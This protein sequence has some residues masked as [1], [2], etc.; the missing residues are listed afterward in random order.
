[1]PGSLSEP[2]I[3]F[4]PGALPRVDNA[5]PL[6]DPYAEV[7]TQ[8]IP[9]LRIEQLYQSP[10]YDLTSSEW[11]AARAAFLQSG[12][13]LVG[14]EAADNEEVHIALRSLKVVTLHNAYAEFAGV[15]L[16]DDWRAP[17]VPLETRRRSKMAELIPRQGVV[18]PDPDKQLDHMDQ[19]YDALDEVGLPQLKPGMRT[20]RDV[21]ER[22]YTRLR[23]FEF[24]AKIG[25]TVPRFASLLYDAIHNYDEGQLDLIN[26]AWLELMRPKYAADGAIHPATAMKMFWEPHINV[27]LMIATYLT[28]T[29]DKHKADFIEVVNTMLADTAEHVRTEYASVPEFLSKMGTA[30]ALR[31][32]YRGRD[33]S[34]LGM[35]MLQEHE[36]NLL[37]Q[38]KIVR[39]ADF[40]TARRMRTAHGLADY[41]LRKVVPYP[42]EIWQEGVA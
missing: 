35:K 34:W 3:L 19:V 31:D 42:R 32:I 39:D 30:V 37:D 23:E 8:P 25:Y 28:H 10:E 21:T 14:S 16:S 24:P 20:Y 11:P 1:M 18:I 41:A 27:D 9:V 7:M 22:V 6:P 29:Q 2:G 15:P 26:R 38:R 12:N 40:R 13:W 17:V 4:E 5:E 33:M 36:G